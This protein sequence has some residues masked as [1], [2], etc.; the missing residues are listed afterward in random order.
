MA[1]RPELLD[2]IAGHEGLA[3]LD[4]ERVV[5]A[6]RD[7][8]G[9][10][11]EVLVRDGLLTEEQLFYLL[12]GEL[13]V[14]VLPEE[15][16]RNL[17]LPP[18]LILPGARELARSR[19]LLPLELDAERGVL[20]VVM[21]DPSDAEALKRL[22]RL[23]RVGQVRPLLA[24]RSTIRAA[25]KGAF[26]SLG[27]GPM[28]QPPTSGGQQQGPPRP[29]DRRPRRRIRPRSDTPIY[30]PKVEVDPGLKQELEAIQVHPPEFEV[31]AQRVAPC[32]ED[33]TTPPL[34]D[35][36]LGRR[37]VRGR[38]LLRDDDSGAETRVF[39]PPQGAAEAGGE[40]NT[41]E[42]DLA[43]IEVDELPAAP[44]PAVDSS[45]TPLP[46]ISQM[47]L[48]DSLLHELLTSVGVL[49]SMLE[50]R[51][52]PAS[53]ACRDLGQL[54]RLV[55][56][57][58]GLD[59]LT[60]SRVTLAAQLHG[61]DL[62]LREEVGEGAAPD[63]VASFSLLGTTPG[64]LGPSLRMMG[65]RALGLPEDGEAEATVGVRLIRLVAQYLQLRDESDEPTLDMETMVQLLRTSAGDADLVDALV[66]AL[67][68]RE[69][70]LVVRG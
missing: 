8:E 14:P 31:K 50:E 24:R 42:L 58:A 30:E 27:R 16:L 69:R 45:L 56:R 1:S 64:G 49:V 20:S 9:P 28:S 51:I 12:S 3:D 22:R 11:A 29:P 63:V 66:R 57:E 54:C 19:S 13:G 26:G 47:E 21:C 6:V 53:G 34:A 5:R 17:Q 2:L 4:L 37:Q 43:D 48:L 61:L 44:E 10:L 65:A 67:E 25:I 7:G 41:Q 33:A 18:A 38:S 39:R 15:R 60:V 35:A 59:E 70:T 46:D 55:A 62:A 40:S 68:G 23:F 36:A 52:D 32:S